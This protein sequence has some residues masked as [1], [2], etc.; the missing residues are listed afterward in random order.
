MR[1]SFCL[2]D[3]GMARAQ[4]FHCV[5]D[6]LDDGLSHWVALR[7]LGPVQPIPAAAHAAGMGIV[8]ALAA[9]EQLAAPSRSDS[10][11]SSAETTCQYASFASMTLGLDSSQEDLSVISFQANLAE[12][13]M[14]ARG[15]PKVSI[16]K[17]MQPAE[18]AKFQGWFKESERRLLNNETC[19]SLPCPSLLLNFFNLA[20][21]AQSASLARLACVEHDAQGFLVKLDEVITVPLSE[22]RRAVRKRGA[23]D[24]SCASKASA[25]TL[26]SIVEEHEGTPHEAE[27]T[28]AL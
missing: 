9:D 13:E 21:F 23:D 2:S 25:Q 8:A 19:D 17:S 20:I 27:Q 1:A 26:G 14:Y 4:L 18:W 28:L 11:A 10:E 3:G 15:S 6:D 12:S 24:K 16:Q 22:A 7:Q 5:D